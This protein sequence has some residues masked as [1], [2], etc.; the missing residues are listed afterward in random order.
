MKDERLQILRMVQEGKLSPEEAARLLEAVEQPAARTEGPRARHVRVRI[1][2]GGK[3]S[4]ISVGTG[5]AR[6]LLALPGALQVDLGSSRLDTEA[7]AQ[8]IE[9]GAPGKVFEAED[10]RRRVEIWLES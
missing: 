9:T 8:A 2:D 6:W 5:V 10:G 7:L 3:V 1:V 4:Q